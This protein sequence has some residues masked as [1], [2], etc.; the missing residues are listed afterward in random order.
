MA[1]SGAVLLEDSSELLPGDK[2]KK[3]QL[4]MSYISALTSRIELACKRN[5]QVTIL[6]TH[7]LK[8][9]LFCPFTI[10]G[11]SSTHSFLIGS[12]KILLLNELKRL[13]ANNDC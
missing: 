7:F 11:P 3:F 2:A 5:K 9:A 8:F 13:K 10:N 4:W 12:R 6:E 1:N